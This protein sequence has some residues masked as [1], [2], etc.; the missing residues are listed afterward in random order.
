[1][2]DAAVTANKAPATLAASPGVFAVTMS[3]RAWPGAVHTSRLTT[4]AQRRAHGRILRAPLVGRPNSG[5]RHGVTGCS[6]LRRFELTRQGHRNRH[7]PD[8]SGVHAA[9]LPRAEVRLSC[10]VI[11]EGRGVIAASVRQR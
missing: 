3:H 11:V 2:A 5:P 4:R 8:A 7:R 6:N 1:V 9:R 10:G